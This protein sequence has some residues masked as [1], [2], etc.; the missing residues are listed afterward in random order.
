MVSVSSTSGRS[1]NLQSIFFQNGCFI[2]IS[3]G[4]NQRIG[5]VT[6][7]ISAS[8]KVSTAKIIPSKND[9]MFVNTVAEKVASMINGI[10]ILSIHSSESLELEDMKAIMGEIMNTVSRVDGHE[11]KKRS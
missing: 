2:A 3:E 6:V 1:F 4:V 10:C 5:A 7:S 8:N 11:Q 9:S